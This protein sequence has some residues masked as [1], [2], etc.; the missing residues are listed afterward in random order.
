MSLEAVTLFEG[1]G[2]DGLLSLGVGAPGEAEL[3]RVAALLKEAATEAADVRPP[4][5]LPP[6]HK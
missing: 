1:P 2:L 3:A 5:H 4:P 6:A